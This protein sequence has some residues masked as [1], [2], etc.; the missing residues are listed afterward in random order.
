MSA[1]GL[2]D[3]RMLLVTDPAKDA[4]DL[5]QWLPRWL[6]TVE[7]AHGENQALQILKAGVLDQQPFH[8]LILDTRSVHLEAAG[9]AERVKGDP[10]LADVE[11]FAA[12]D[13]SDHLKELETAGYRQVF[14]TPLDKT[15]IFNDLHHALVKPVSGDSDVARLM[16]YYVQPDDGRPVKVLL[17]E[18]NPVNQKV[19]S[20]ILERAGHEVVIVD[21]GKQVLERLETDNDIDVA[22]CDMHMP[23]MGGIEAMKL[24]RFAQPA[25]QVPFLILT[26]N[27]TTEARQECD[28]AGADGFLTK[29]VQAH[30]LYQALDELTTPRQEAPVALHPRRAEESKDATSLTKL[31][32]LK[33]LSPDAA[34]V[35]DLIKVFLDDAASL[36]SQMESAGERGDPEELKRLAHSFKGSAASIGA[37]RLCDVCTELDRLSTN[38]SAERIT[39][40]LRSVRREL[41]QVRTEL[42]GYLAKH[43]TEASQ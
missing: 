40:L 27:A 7:T 29:P 43:D 11:L 39:A 30:A 19:I 12:T 21:D 24:H 20:K 18:D 38:V 22:V 1:G 25:R 5:S 41:E 16:D 31:A 13:R 15:L 26:A 3:K 42:E 9:F 35:D 37:Q 8:G 34:F 28:E 14:K 36:L 17:A 32:E 23:V 6:T 4:G 33:A 10:S 2:S